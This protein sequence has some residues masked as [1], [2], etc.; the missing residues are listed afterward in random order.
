MVGERD[1]N[2]EQSAQILRE[3]LDLPAEVPARDD[4]TVF[5]VDDPRAADAHAFRHTHVRDEP[6]DY[7]RDRGH[8]CPVIAA[9]GRG[10]FIFFENV[11]ALV[12][13]AELYERAAEID[14][15][16]ITHNFAAAS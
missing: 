14:S 15:D 1:G 4:H 5:A 6:L 16:T 10:D 3:R 9:R 12:D 8:G 13:C 7:F 11:S 2:A